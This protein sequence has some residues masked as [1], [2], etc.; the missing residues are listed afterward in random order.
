MVRNRE[1]VHKVVR[2]LDGVA[3]KF[4]E[5]VFIN[6]F[7]SDGAAEAA[8]TS[9]VEGKL[10]HVDHPAFPRRGR[11]EIDDYAGQILI[12]LGAVGHNYHILGHGFGGVWQG[13]TVDDSFPGWG[14]H[15]GHYKQPM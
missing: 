13:R 2:C 1:G 9:A 3:Q 12:I 14:L 8:Q 6:E 10:T 11:T 5:A 15:R 7:A 4:V